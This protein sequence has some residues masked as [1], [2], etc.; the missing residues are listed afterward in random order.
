MHWPL[1]GKTSTASPPMTKP[2]NNYGHDSYPGISTPK[3]RPLKMI[4]RRRLSVWFQ[5]GSSVEYYT[6]N[7]TVVRHFTWLDFPKMFLSA[8]LVW[9]ILLL[10]HF[11]STTM[12]L[13]SRSR[14]T[15]KQNVCWPTQYQKLIGLWTI[16]SGNFWQ[17]HQKM[18]MS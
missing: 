1:Y 7:I 6:R 3:T 9:S 16:S 2:E 15:Q 17:N 11:G 13:T 8:T 4:Q 12:T 10:I 14:Q 5:D 18:P